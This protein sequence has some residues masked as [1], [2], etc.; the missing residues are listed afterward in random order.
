MITADMVLINGKVCTVDRNFRFAEAV[1]VRNGW[2][3]DVGSSEEIKAYIGPGTE[4]I[5]LKGRL[6]LPGAF[7][8]HIHATYAG[9]KAGPDYIRVNDCKTIEALA[10]RMAQEAAKVPKGTWL[11]GGNIRPSELFP[12]ETPNCKLLDQY[13]PDHPIILHESDMHGALINSKAMELSHFTK[14]LPDPEIANG[15]LYRWPNGEP[16]G[17]IYQYVLQSYVGK[18]IPVCTP[19]Q[20]EENVKRIQHHLNQDGITSHVD[21]IGIGGDRIFSGTWGSPA[22]EAY[23]RLS[24]KGELTARCS[25]N[26]LAGLNGEQSYDA[27]VGGLDR[28]KLP[29]FQDRNWV[30]A[31]AVKIFGE[32][33]WRRV[34]EAMPGRFG[35]C[36]FTGATVEEQVDNMRR[37]LKELHRRGW[38][39]GIHLT[40]GRGIDAFIDAFVDAEREYPREDLRHFIIHGDEIDPKTIAK[41][42]KYK[43]MLSAQAVA[44]Y[45]F[46]EGVAGALKGDL[47]ED[48]FDYQYY[49]DQGMVVSQGSDYPGMTT[50]WRKGLQFCLTRTT[51]SGNTFR[52]D[53]R[54]N[55]QDV[56]RMYTINGAYQNHMEDVCGSIEVN[57]LADFQVLGA[58]LFQTPAEE[59]GDVPVVMTIC[60]GKVV[61]CAE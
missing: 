54:C 60:G 40:G 51:Q 32:L 20:M 46:M 23:E 28:M 19:E 35:A 14:D 43:I 31:D 25:V 13:V 50:N 38:Q 9:Y 59:V 53:L 34:D 11:I 8:E 15:T 21:I 44:P 29:E 18:A 10:K 41:C 6:V 47:G 16:T 37:T 4:V 45:S 49:L 5:D 7:D 17:Y 26:I 55:I 33:G 61:Y 24:R 48:L 52:K 39:M 57:K 12:N 27:I 42:A 36:S 1:A 30:R 3:I 2:I 58:D 22:I 56:I